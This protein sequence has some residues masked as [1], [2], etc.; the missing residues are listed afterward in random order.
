MKRA[1]V[2]F[3]LPDT[4][5][6]K[7]VDESNALVLPATKTKKQ[8]VVQPVCKKKPLT[9]KQRKNLEKVLEQKEKKARVCCVFVCVCKREC[10]EIATLTV[11]LIIIHVLY[12]KP[13]IKK[14][15]RKCLLLFLK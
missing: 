9:K 13:S 1:K 10:S 6:L 12:I 2:Y 5:V 15:N 11:L 14:G 7:G 8:K 4:A 3:F